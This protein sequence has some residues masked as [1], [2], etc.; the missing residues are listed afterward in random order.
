[1]VSDRRVPYAFCQ[2]PLLPVGL[3]ESAGMELG[4]PYE[5]DREID[6]EIVYS[7]RG[8]GQSS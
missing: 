7:A 2:P 8:P 3:L 6:R 4:Q 5:I 1:M